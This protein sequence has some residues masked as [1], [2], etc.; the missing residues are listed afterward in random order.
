MRGKSAVLFDAGG[1]LIT[2]D[3]D[4]LRTA[5]AVPYELLP[6][7]QLDA[8][9]AEARIWVDGA[10]RRG[11]STRELWDGYFAR[12]IGASGIGSAKNSQALEA[13]WQAN[14]DLGLWRRPI[15][16][17]RETLATLSEAGLRL[18]VVSNAEGQVE[19]DLRE[20]GLGAA[21]ETVV[22]SFLV[23][24]AKPDPRI[25]EIALERLG[26]CADDV[27]YVGD[28]PAYDVVGARAAGIDPVLV[29]P[30][31]I[32]GHID[33]LRIRHLGQLPALL[34]IS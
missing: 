32:H 19:S 20:A 3:Y 27:I 25:F 2:L 29:D 9:D 34:G 17:A 16:G 5:L 28:L 7:L 13:L 1:T 26:L 14:Q 30:H 31:D 4:A 11:A 21:L 22:D 18:A 23:G 24:A 33:A 6:D 12:L 10:V 8:A 15:P